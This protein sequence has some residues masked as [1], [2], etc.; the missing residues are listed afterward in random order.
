MG[1]PTGW[2]SIYPWWYADERARIAKRF[3]DFRVSN[4]DLKEGT[5]AYKGTIKLD[6][7]SRVELNHVL[8]YYDE[9]TP[10]VM[11]H[12]F[13]LIALPEG[14][15][16][17]ADEVLRTGV[18]RMPVGYRR[19][20]MAR[21]GSSTGVGN[22][23]LIEQGTGNSAETV[24]GVDVL[25]RAVEVFRAVAHGKPFPF[26]DA[27]ADELEAHFTLHGDILLGEAFFASDLAKQGKLWAVSTMDW[28]PGMPTFV[29]QTDP[30]R[31]LFVGLHL[32]AESG[33]LIEDWRTDKT[34]AI[35]RAFPFTG[36]GRLS[37]EGQSAGEVEFP[38]SATLEGPWYDLPREPE[39]FATGGE[40]ADL[41]QAELGFK[42]GVAELLRNFP[43]FGDGSTAWLALRYPGREV[44]GFRWVVVGLRSQ[45]VLDKTQLKKDGEGIRRDVLRNAHLIAKRCHRI[46]QSDLE[47][48]N[49]GTLPVQLKNS[50]ALIL[51]CGALG[52][53]VALTLANAGIKRLILA[54]RDVVAAGNVVRHVA[55]LPMV[56]LKKPDAL[57]SIIHQHN[58]F[59]EVLVWPKSATDPR[60]T[61]DELLSEADIAISTIADDGIEQVVNE[62][63]VR[64]G[65]TVIYG[66]AYRSGSACRV[67]RVRPGSDACLMCAARYRVAVE[68]GGEA[69]WI[70]V[71][72]DKNELV[73]RE[74]GQAIIA[75]SAA[76]LRFAAIFTAGAA[77]DEIGGGVTW[78][79]LLFVREPWPAPPPSL[80]SPLSIAKES[81]PP[82]SD[83][84]VCG[85]PRVN[86]IEFEPKAAA[87]LRGFAEAK[88]KVETGG[89]LIG[90]EENG[91][92]IVREVTDAGP[93]AEEKATHFR[94]DADYV[95]G[96][97]RDAADRLGEKGVYVGEWHTH[98]EAK[99]RPSIRDIESLTDIA[100]APNFLT[101]EPVMI[102]AGLD[103][104][105]GKVDGVHSSSFPIGRRPRDIPLRGWV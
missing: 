80:S 57:R 39:P 79:N 67:M 29:R 60:E 92:V 75:G 22:I 9:Q 45:E 12:L 35:R 46:A 100:T 61:I 47:L 31:R 65:K 104:G 44:G 55:G 70:V 33:K 90:S 34:A 93:N 69:K 38:E 77:L 50:S 98:L 87:L 41:L 63:A 17:N 89:V 81:F 19:H 68:K 16:W 1:A 20:Q 4:A 28:Y 84:P 88:Q 62:A 13:P 74:C 40:L 37:F 3:P 105:T 101:D 102:I 30:E 8:L 26:P 43:A 96:K 53:D 2:I 15:D 71:P 49:K 36:A 51:G 23:C 10:F 48:R 56:G 5:L 86:A 7:G 64:T 78:N 97:L 82:K 73:G 42:D 32:T 21:F 66:R 25:S 18:R 52:G 6:L 76:D 14:D 85:R 103:P 59:V 99:P 91:V 95:N 72:E 24:S 11:P 54:D 27:L 94:Y 83:C 58:P